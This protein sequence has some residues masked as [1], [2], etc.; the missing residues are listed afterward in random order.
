MRKQFVET[1]TDI[2]KTDN[3]T[4]LLLGDIGIY[5]FSELMNSYPDRVFNIGILEQATIGVAAGMS[6]Q[7]LIP[8]VHTIAP[9]IIERALEQLKIDFGYQKLKGNFVSVGASYDY[10]SLGPTHHCPGDAEIISS[11][12]GF[13]IFSPGNAKE[14]NELFN[15]FYNKEYPNYFRLSELEHS[16]NINPKPGKG[17][18][19]KRGKE[20][21][22]VSIGNMLA[23]TKEIAD[24]I[25]VSHIYIN[26]IIPLDIELI[27]NELKITN[28]KKIIFVEPFYIGT[29][30]KIFLSYVDNL[31]VQICNIGIPR[32]FIDKYG[33]REEVDSYF[34]LDQKGIEKKIKDALK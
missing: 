9:F 17:S 10:A 20:G 13:N 19:I 25:D 24:E 5:G 3:S 27:L 1:L 31:L 11:I 22:V 29:V 2:I 4:T 12:P 15:H 28:T 32:K 6:I 21:L 33:K 23:S 8:T 30:S 34:G 7:N 14:F 18:L 26:S 16:F